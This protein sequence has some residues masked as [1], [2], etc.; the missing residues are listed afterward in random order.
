[1]LRFFRHIRQRLFLPGPEGS[2][3]HAPSGRVSRYIG[4][5]VGEIVLIVVGIMIA[6]ELHAANRIVLKAEAM[7]EYLIER[8]LDP[9]KKVQT[10]QFMKGRYYGGSIVDPSMD[11]VSFEDIVQ[12]M[13]VHLRKRNYYPEPELGKSDLLFVVHYGVTG[14]QANSLI[15]NMGVN[16]ILDLEDPFGNSNIL[17]NNPSNIDPGVQF[18]YNA[19]LSMQEAHYKASFR[20]AQLLG[21]EQAYSLKGTVR[22]ERMLNLMIQ[23]ERYFVVLMAWDFKKLQQGEPI[24]LWRMR[25]NIRSTGQSFG[26]AIQE[27]HQIAGDYFGTN[28]QD[29]VMTR[30]TDKSRV[31]IGEIEVIEQIEDSERE[32]KE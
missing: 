5:A 25:Y 7:E 24:L 28:Q 17:W 26:Q 13:A 15:E 10:Y 11:R 6:P 4:Y 32:Q 18:Y 31:V 8:A 30:I 14:L 19:S 2:A 20:K 16:S 3:G 29:L 27:M 12:N 23:E 21:M 22:E 1:M 9:S